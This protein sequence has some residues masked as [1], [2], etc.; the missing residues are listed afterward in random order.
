[1]AAEGGRSDLTIAQR[2]LE[3][4]LTDEPYCFE[5]F[6]AVRLIERF[7][8]RTP[9]GLF[10]NPRDEVA[11]F[12]V[13]N[14]LI[15]PASEI[16]SLTWREE[17]PP[18]MRVNFMGLTGPLGALPLYYTQLV[19]ERIRARDTA[20]CD[21]LDI[22]NHRIISLFYQAWEKYR[23]SLEYERGGRD[24]FS[25]HLLDFIGLGTDGLQDRQKV[26]DQSLMYYAGLL[27]QQP[28]SA[29]ALRQLLEDYFDVPVAVEQFAGAWY[30]LT[31]EMQC[32]LEREP[33]DSER[34]AVGAVVGDEIWDEQ[35]RV[36]IV[37][38]PLTLERYLDFLPNGTA[39]EPL[40]G[41][42]RFF[43]GDQLD[44]EVQLVLKRGEVPACELGRED[45]EAPLLGWVSW[46]K[47]APMPRDP[48]DAVLEL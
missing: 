17:G 22:F 5:F 21:F 29:V 32:C 48:G 36:R 41:L 8:H 44:F 43:S 7:T 12:G 16:L 47:S 23:F 4:Q 27:G 2:A 40:R 30:R 46:A 18:L 6:Q 15:F 20:L 26:A 39:F 38:G 11:R 37:L 45:S 33:S 42:T 35:T 31:P 19:S 28:R 9:V 3:Q 10:A 1:M 14:T 24:P 34:V 25:H 13:H